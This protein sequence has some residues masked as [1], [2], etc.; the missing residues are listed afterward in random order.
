MYR[1]HDQG[2]A[3]YEVE[4]LILMDMYL[5][6][7]EEKTLANSNSLQMKIN[8]DMKNSVN[9]REKTLAISQQFAKFTNFFS[10]PP[11][12]FAL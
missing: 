6:Y 8:T 11:T 1:S 2:H 5:Y 10:L 9:L 3:D 7:L 12:F 4:P